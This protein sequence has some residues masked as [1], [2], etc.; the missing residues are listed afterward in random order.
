MLTIQDLK[1]KFESLHGIVELIGVSVNYTVSDALI[2]R[3]RVVEVASH[4]LGDD[5]AKLVPTKTEKSCVSRAVKEAAKTNGRFND[6]LARKVA[7]TGEKAVYGVISE[8]RDEN[9]EHNSYEQGSTLKLDKKEKTVTAEGESAEK[10]MELYQQYT[11]GITD[12]DIR[13]FCV[14]VMRSAKGVAK[15]PSGSE[16]IVPIGYAGILDGLDA[17]LRDL[18]IGRTF[19]TAM[20][21]DEISMTNTWEAAK[22]VIKNEVDS[23]MQNIDNITRQQAGLRNRQNKL[24]DLTNLA[25]IYGELTEASS[26]AEELAEM[27]NNQSDAVAERIA[28]VQQLS[29]ERKIARAKAAKDALENQDDDDT[30]DQDDE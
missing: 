22:R 12:E 29:V 2:P 8:T 13:S 10:L 24:S 20:I 15:N 4:Y 28:K 26:E 3:E 5:L 1:S 19:P 6:K 16:Y 30:Q 23:T 17:F 14:R 18:G 7:D 11:Q 21:N 27:I 9:A 25:K